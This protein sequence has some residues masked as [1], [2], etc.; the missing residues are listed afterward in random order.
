M[1]WK[2]WSYHYSTY[3]S[4]IFFIFFHN[5]L[6]YF[7]NLFTIR[8]AFLPYFPNHFTNTEENCEM[9][10]KIWKKIVKWFGEYGRKAKSNSEKIWK[11]QKKIV[12]WY[13]FPNHFTIQLIFLP[14][15]PYHFTFQLTF[16]PYF[17]YLITIRLTFL[18]YFS[19]FF[20]IFFK[21]NSEKIWKIQKKIVK[22]YEKYGR[23]VSRIVIR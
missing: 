8:L 6:L 12:K 17:P 11:I 18:P 16:L 20:T 19:Y 1:I 7:P 14:Y 10:W 22:K 9:I 23:K 13:D 5:F 2:I 3:F 4:S 15:F 21:S